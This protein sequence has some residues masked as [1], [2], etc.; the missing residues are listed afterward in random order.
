MLIDDDDEA[1]QN[2]LDKICGSNHDLFS[3]IRVPRQRIHVEI[4]TGEQKGIDAA[5]GDLARKKDVGISLEK[6]SIIKSTI[7]THFIN[8]RISFTPMET[9]LTIPGELE[10]VEGLVKLARRRK[11]EEHITIPTNVMA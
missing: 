11:N 7:F 9:I 5:E 4:N 10:Y 1:V 3:H 2:Q 6:T 8:G